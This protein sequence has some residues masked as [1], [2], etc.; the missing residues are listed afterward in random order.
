MNTAAADAAA[1]RLPILTLAARLAHTANRA[2][3]QLH[4]IVL[5]NA[6]Q[7]VGPHGGYSE[8]NADG[9]PL[10][11]CLTLGPE[12][13]KVRLLGDP[14]W[15]LRY[16]KDRLKASEAALAESF[17]A[18]DAAGLLHSAKDL[19]SRAQLAPEGIEAFR[20]GFVWVAVNLAA[21]GAAVYLDAQPLGAQA[22]MEAE[23]WLEYILPTSRFARAVIAS[24][25]PLADL[26]SLS[27]EGCT[28]ADA[29]AKLYF[30]LKQ[31]LPLTDLGIELFTDPLLLGF[32]HRMIGA[33]EMNLSGLTLSIGFSLADG[34]LTDVKADVCAHCLP[35][36]TAQ[37]SALIA[38]AAT[39]MGVA[40][41]KLDAA[42]HDGTCEMAN[43]GLGM[44]VARRPRLNLYLKP[45]GMTAERASAGLP[46]DSHHRL[47]RALDWLVA[48]QD[49]DGA[50][51]DY[52][53]P[54]G[55]ACHWVTGFT[56]CA[57]AEAA[58]PRIDAALRAAIFLEHAARERAGW[59]Y[60]ATTPPDADSTGFAL[61]LLRATQCSARAQD[62]DLLVAHWQPQGGF[63]TYFGPDH[64]GDVHPCVT[65]AA[66]QALP[67]EEQQLRYRALLSYLQ[68]TARADGTWPAYWWCNH[69]YSTWHHL[70]LLRRFGLQA[71]FPVPQAI[72]LASQASN[73][74]L[75]YAAGIE[76][77]CGRGE[78][79]R[80]LLLA[81]FDRQRVDGGWAGGFNLRVTD[82]DC[83][84]PWQSP[85]GRLYR[86]LHGIV[87]TA[88]VV[89]VLNEMHHG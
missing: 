58:K 15:R 40:L 30:R 19:L 36:S 87:T 9:W 11:L 86:D 2:V 49:N 45:P 21:P 10:Q 41:P 12:R 18:A 69:L 82:P 66:F 55:E 83:A 80:R 52:Q 77:F 76:W 78:R 20:R 7:R 57:L 26:A 68:T 74:E 38:D 88:S 16:P 42:L 8:L 44:D 73:F 85:S 60:N 5:A 62:L 46:D 14:G 33:R 64:W 79:A 1:F 24:L 25:S 31:A 89:F 37:W 71:R 56:G 51:R 81:L 22:W 75:A 17:V 39:I 6:Y 32:L 84:Q 67:Q 53:L 65:A 70:K 27:L 13:T 63:S 72:E 28:P 47:Q 54:I 34:Q 3:D 29:R 59:G 4:A 61:R 50:W 43:L 35:Q 23:A 48:C